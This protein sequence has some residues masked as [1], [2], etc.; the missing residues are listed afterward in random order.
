M[1][2]SQRFD[3]NVH[4]R[5]SIRLRGYDYAS[6]GMYFV[7]IVTLGR[8]CL[9]GDVSSDEM[10]LNDGGEL[11]R[12]AWQELPN[13]FPA[14]AIDEFVVMPNHISGILVINE[15]VGAPCT[16]PTPWMHMPTPCI[17][18]PIPRA[19]TPPVGQTKRI[20]AT[21]AASTDV[22]EPPRTIAPV[23]SS[24]CCLYGCAGTSIRCPAQR[25]RNVGACDWRVQITDD[26]SLRRGCQIAEVDAV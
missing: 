3:P 4:H 15:T 2:S 20:A 14:V 26:R 18:P 19:I 9:F 25:P 8:L 13:R 16:P 12:R 23:G 22:Q 21:R 5:R 17:L 1:T 10:R 6:A 11:I 24:T 7:T